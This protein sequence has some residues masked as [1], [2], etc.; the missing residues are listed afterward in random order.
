MIQA[1]R[2]VATQSRFIKSWNTILLFVQHFLGPAHGGDH[3]GKAG[4]GYGEQDRMADFI[5]CGL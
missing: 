3:I 5:L 2:I 1:F 4:G